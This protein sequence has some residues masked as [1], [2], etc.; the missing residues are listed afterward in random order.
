LSR[1]S[2]KVTTKLVTNDLKVSDFIKSSINRK[3]RVMKTYIFIVTVAFMSN[4]VCAQENKIAITGNGVEIE[5][6]EFSQQNVSYSGPLTFNNGYSSVKTNTTFV[7]GNKI[8]ISR[9][10]Y[11]PAKTAVNYSYVVYA[12]Y[13]KDG[14]FDGPQEMVYTSKGTIDAQSTVYNGK[15]ASFTIPASVA[16]GGLTIRV[17]LRQGDETATP[18]GGYAGEIEDYTINVSEKAV[19]APSQTASVF[20]DNMNTKDRL[21]TVKTP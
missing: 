4:T 21:P 10:I 1:D 8:F 20:P 16:L 2:S 14:N 12:D 6:T 9:N 15:F 3:N 19:T 18:N 11:N 7:K 17:A 5:Q 13:N